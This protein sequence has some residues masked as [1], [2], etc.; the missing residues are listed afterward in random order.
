MQS[1]HNNH[2]PTLGQALGTARQRLQ[3][4]SPSPAVD[5]SILLCHV[6]GC[7]PGHLIAW[8][9]K[10]LT[11][12][13]AKQFERILQQRIAGEPVA[14]ITGAREFWSL[15]LKISSDVLIPRPETETLVEF[16]LA[17]FPG[18][19]HLAVADLG[20]GS[21]AIACAL[22]AEHPQWDIVATDTSVAALEIARINAEAHKLG[23]IRF[24]QGT[25]FEPLAGHRFDLVISNPPYVANGDPHLEQGDVRFEPDSALV[26]GPL[27]MDAISLITGAA[28]QHLNTGGWLIIEHGYDQQQAVYDCFSQAGF[29]DIAQLNDLAGQPRMTAGR[30]AESIA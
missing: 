14:Y 16:A 23:N 30:N 21:G 3:A 9:E 19:A 2:T 10:Q 25:W 11:Q 26:S 5:A 13:Q 28:G 4:T 27:G 8:P 1:S 15:S 6:L 24:L 12:T 7:S 18:S 29:E 22:A 17:K 20:T